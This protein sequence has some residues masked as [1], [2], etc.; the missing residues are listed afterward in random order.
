MSDIKYPGITLRWCVICDHSQPVDTVFDCKCSPEFKKRRGIA[1]PDKPNL[2]WEWNDYCQW[3]EAKPEQSKTNIYC[4]TYIV[5][6]LFGD[7]WTAIMFHPN[8]AGQWQHPDVVKYSHNAMK[9][10]ERHW[11]GESQ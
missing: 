2:V 3:W 9:L 10:C 1:V 5:K 4:D 6:R 7:N 8:R 11:Q